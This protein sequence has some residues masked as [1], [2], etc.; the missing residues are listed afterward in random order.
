MV[1]R[2]PNIC[3]DGFKMS[4]KVQSTETLNAIILVIDFKMSAHKA[5]L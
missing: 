3:S 1:Q 2:T 5:G 4:Q